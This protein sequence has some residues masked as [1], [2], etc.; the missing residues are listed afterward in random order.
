MS[1]SSSR[2]SWPELSPVVAEI[3]RLEN[4]PR[5]SAIHGWVSAGPEGRQRCSDFIFGGG[6]DWTRRL[7]VRVAVHRLIAIAPD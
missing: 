3:A 1:R 7:R 2:R 4:H 6:Y 5:E